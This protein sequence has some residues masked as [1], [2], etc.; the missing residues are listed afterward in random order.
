[1]RIAL[2]SQ[3]SLLVLLTLF[4]ALT[5]ITSFAQTLTTLASFNETNGAYP[6]ASLVQG[7]DGNLYGAILSGGDNPN[8]PPDGCGTVVKISPQGTVTRLYRGSARLTG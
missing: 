4:C 6:Y 1:M 5:A 3:V 7:I 8:C 2:R